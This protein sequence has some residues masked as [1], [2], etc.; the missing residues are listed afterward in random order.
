M[1]TVA[2]ICNLTT[3]NDQRM[4]TRIDARVGA[5]S[6]HVTDYDY[7]NS[8]VAIVALGLVEPPGITQPRGPAS[9]EP[10]VNAHGRIPNCSSSCPCLLE[11]VDEGR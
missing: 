4:K 9:L 2:F 3:D 10:D 11:P 7:N 8:A 5:R 6:R 1:N